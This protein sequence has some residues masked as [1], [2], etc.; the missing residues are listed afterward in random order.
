M[1]E[2]DRTVESLASTAAASAG[3]E[4]DRRRAATAGERAREARALEARRAAAYA[5]FAGGEGRDTMAARLAAV[6]RGE[7]P[8][9]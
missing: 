5:P 4:L 7:G 6:G 1:A 9:A 3:R 2:Y 8:G